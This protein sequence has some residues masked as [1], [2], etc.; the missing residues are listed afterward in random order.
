MKRN[1]WMAALALAAL[2]V[3]ACVARVA[4]AQGQF[5]MIYG[6]SG[7]P[8]KGTIIKM[9]KTDVTMDAN[10]IERKFAVNT[11]KKLTFVDDPLELRRARDAIIQGQ[12][13]EAKDQ[14]GNIDMASVSREVVKQDIAFYKALANARLALGG[15]GSQAK[16]VTEMLAFV[17]T[18]SGNFHYYE[19]VET[20]GDLA[21]ALGIYD[22]A[23]VYY[24]ELGRAPW[25]DYK[26]RAAVSEARALQAQKKYADALQKFSMVASSDMTT[27]EAERQKVYAG[28]GRAACLAQTDQFAEG[29]TIIEGMIVKNDPADYRLFARAYV[30]L[31][32]CH[33]KAAKPKDALLAYLHV[34][35]LFYRDG[36][37]HAEALFYLNRLW[38]EIGETEKATQAR[39]LLKQKYPGS[40]WVRNL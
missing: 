27:P 24:K 4:P 39:N 19:A 2:A 34:D 7:V 13:E 1:R 29:V 9:S 8:A 10:T 20:L 21:V 18:G 32:A 30:A 3:V 22:K 25:P 31:G 23:E 17:R 12:L 11:I 26:M 14:L 6:S 33:R 38:D 15:T 35:I 5:D 28:I 40:V 37:S 36:E 16:A